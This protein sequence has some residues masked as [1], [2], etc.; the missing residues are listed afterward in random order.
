MQVDRHRVHR[1][2]FVRPRTNEARERSGQELVV[3]QPG[4]FPLDVA[5]DGAA[6]PRIQLGQ[7]TVACAP[8]HQP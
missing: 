3:G 5:F 4:T 8:G 1:H 2:D 6:R 7:N